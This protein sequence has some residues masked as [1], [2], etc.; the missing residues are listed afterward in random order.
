[1]NICLP[2]KVGINKAFSLE[3]IIFVKTLNEAFWNAVVFFKSSFT[4]VSKYLS[5]LN[6]TAW[7]WA[8]ENLN[9]QN[10]KKDQSIM[11][12]VIMFNVLCW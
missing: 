5:Y 10:K 3:L 9:S 1:M 2:N 11:S 4:Y 7:M 6:R 12:N 8:T